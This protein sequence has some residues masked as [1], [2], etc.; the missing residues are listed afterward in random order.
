MWIYV[1]VYFIVKQKDFAATK[2]QW[3]PLM[4][5][6]VAHI[7]LPNAVFLF[8]WF[9][10][11]FTFHYSPPFMLQWL[12]YKSSTISAIDTQ[13]TVSNWCM[14]R[15]CLS[16]PHAHKSIYQ[17]IVV[18]HFCKETNW[19][20]VFTWLSYRTS[21]TILDISEAEFSIC[22]KTRILNITLIPN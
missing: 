17:C 9:F 14:H 21:W 12:V 2:M 4:L 10:L 19:W 7:L 8:V 11:I 22:R 18:L 13:W 20:V 16:L 3:W 15:F 6:I 1:L 5:K